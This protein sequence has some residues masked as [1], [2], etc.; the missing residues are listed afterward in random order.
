MNNRRGW[1]LGLEQLAAR[2][3]HLVTIEQLDGLGFSREEIRGS[4]ERRYPPPHP[5]RR[6][7]RRDGSAR[8]PR[9]AFR[10]AARLRGHPFSATARAPRSG[11]C[12]RSIA[13][14]SM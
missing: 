5:P 11:V 1:L 10:R 13:G 7:R 9:L 6:L 12:D 8:P 14:R 4:S 2:Q 3:E